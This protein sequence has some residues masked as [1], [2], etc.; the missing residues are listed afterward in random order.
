MVVERRPLLMISPMAGAKESST[1]QIEDSYL[2][3]E[4]EAGSNENPPQNK[5]VDGIQNVLEATEAMEAE[6]EALMAPKQGPAL[7]EPPAVVKEEHPRGAHT[8]QD[9]VQLEVPRKRANTTTMRLTLN[10]NLRC[11]ETRPCMGR[12]H[13]RTWHILIPK[14]GGRKA[15]PLVLSSQW[16]L[17]QTHAPNP[18]FVRIDHGIFCLSL[19]SGPNHC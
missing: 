6:I 2:Y 19:N 5:A 3:E 12:Y 4:D 10:P 9:Q 7:Q 14:R 17:R 13:L 1:A 18:L 15:L 16:T 11:L 8:G